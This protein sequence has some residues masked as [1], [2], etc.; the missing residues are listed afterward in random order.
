MI[1]AFSLTPLG[2]GEDVSK[3]LAPAIKIV[4]DS[5]LPNQTNAMFTLIEGDWDPVMTVVKQ[6][7]EAV[8]AHAPRV[9]MVLKADLRPGVTDGLTSKVAKVEQLLDERSA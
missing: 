4:R 1:I 2:V 6:A 8:A 9:S 7:Y 5:G 3:A